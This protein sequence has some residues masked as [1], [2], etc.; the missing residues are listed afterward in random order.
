MNKYLGALAAAIGLV[1][2][3]FT[4]V[5]AGVVMTE[6]ETVVSGQPAGT[7]QQPRERTMMVEG[8][9]QKTIINGGR[10]IIVD[11][12]KSTMDIIDPSQKSYFEMSFPPRGMMGQAVGS[13][14]M[15]V[16]E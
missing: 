1:T 15:H 14:G 3:S 9:K 11:L 6:T 2:W 4:A 5:S 13:P 12:D 7:P 10:A 8:N 16:S